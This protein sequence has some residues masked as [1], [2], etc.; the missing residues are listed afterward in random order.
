MAEYRDPRTGLRPGEAPGDGA[1]RYYREEYPR[2]DY[3]SD[4][5][6]DGTDLKTLL[7][8]LNNDATQLAHDE[9]ELAKLEIRQVAQAFSA[10]IH[11]AGTTL[12]QNMAKVGAALV[13]GALAGL[14]LTAGA[15]LG[16][17]LLVGA[18]WAGGLIV[19]G[20]LLIG[21]VI[22]A[23]SA[24]RDLKTSTELRLEHGRETLQENTRVMKQEARDTKEFAQEEAQAFKRHATPPEEPR[25][26]A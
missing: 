8:R 17:G 15:I 21:A 9:I 26:H 20:V 22:L 5:R 14:A 16:I 23:M 12:V 19:G 7:K 13:M 18:Y 6:W 4:W 3:R 2:E 25:R 1:G 10:D 11:K 24:A